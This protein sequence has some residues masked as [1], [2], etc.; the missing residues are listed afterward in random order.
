VTYRDFRRPP[1]SRGP[2]TSGDWVTWLSAE[3]VLLPVAPSPVASCELCHG[4]T[5]YRSVIDTWRTCSNCDKYEGA[6]DSY[7]PITYSLDVGLE[8]ILHRFKDFGGFEWL[9]HPMASLL[10]EFLVRHRAC[11][12]S[13]GPAGKV[14]VATIVPSN[15]SRN[16]NHL[17][18]ILKGVFANEPVLNMWDWNTEF[19]RRDRAVTKPGRGELKPSSYVVDPF[20]VE[21]SQVLLLDDT[22]TSG[23]SSASTAA[24]LKDAGAA[25]VTVL[26][27]GRQLNLQSAYGSTGAIYDS[28]ADRPWD[29]GVCVICA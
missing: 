23:A 26:T 8:S 27:L 14:D 13:V 4:A 18:H 24:A 3:G 2:H 6:V 15:D 28:V 25:H 11:I 9:R 7:V 19:V 16:F 29:V 5:G 17:E 20:V 1:F 10:Y 22:W 21:G 12:D